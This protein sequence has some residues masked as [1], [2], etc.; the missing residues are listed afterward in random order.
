MKDITPRL[1]TRILVNGPLWPAAFLRIVWM[2]CTGVPGA[3]GDVANVWA[4]LAGCS[5]VEGDCA[6]MV[7]RVQ[8]GL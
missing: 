8:V 4:S 1:A 2:E 7:V 3:L 5:E 6:D